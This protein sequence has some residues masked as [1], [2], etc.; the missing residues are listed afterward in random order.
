MVTLSP[1]PHRPPPRHRAVRHRLA[2]P[3]LVLTAVA[4][5]ALT[6]WQVAGSEDD[7]GADDAATAPSAT[8]TSAAPDSTDQATPE[9]TPQSTPDGTPA[10]APE[11]FVEVT[12]D[13]DQA[14]PMQPVPLR[15]QIEGAPTGAAVEVQ[16]FDDDRW[17]PFPLRPV[18]DESGGFETYVEL[19]E[20]GVHRLRVQE[21]VTGLTSSTFTIR[22]R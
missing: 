20:R 3:A 22:V 8:S 7:A 10:G 13:T 19:G 9:G 6:L 12:L 21:P 11:G 2:V 4:V 14:A 16:L 18:V 17:V 1:H 5:L 15:G